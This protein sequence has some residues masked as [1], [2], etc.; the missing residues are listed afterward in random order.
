PPVGAGAAGAVDRDDVSACAH[1]CEGEIEG[2]GDEDAVLTLLHQPDAGHREVGA[3]FGDVLDPLGAHARGPAR[4]D[5]R[6]DAAHRLRGAQ[7]PP[8]PAFAGPLM[9]TVRWARI[10]AMSS[11][12]W[13]RT[14]AAPP[15]T[16]ACA[17]R[18][19]V[20]GV[21]IGSPG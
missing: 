2:G 3:R 8:S 21:R 15:A 6:R 11:I 1:A 16:T 14:P 7:T 20:S 5:G 19:I 4:D 10:S 18:R 12:P 13:A 9:G 17:T